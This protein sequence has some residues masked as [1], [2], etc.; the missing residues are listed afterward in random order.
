[1]LK[2]VKLDYKLE[3]V[4]DEETRAKLYNLHEEHRAAFKK[5][6]DAEKTGPKF[7]P[8]NVQN[9][10]ISVNNLDPYPIQIEVINPTSVFSTT[11]VSK[12]IE[13]LRLARTFAEANK[14]T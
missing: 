4:V 9:M 11:N 14:K 2:K 7:E 1:M 8:I 10:T 5:L 6:L 3:A 13:A 12:A